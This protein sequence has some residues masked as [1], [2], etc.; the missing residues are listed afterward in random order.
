MDRLQ[1]TYN[2]ALP[3]NYI[4]QTA[5]TSHQALFPAVKFPG[6]TA[7]DGVEITQSFTQTI[8]LVV[9]QF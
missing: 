6:S 5:N 7:K 2:H 4:V 1:V 3:L 9:G 8:R